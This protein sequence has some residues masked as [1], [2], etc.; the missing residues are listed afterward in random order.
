MNVTGPQDHPVSSDIWEEPEMKRALVDRDVSTVYRLLRRVGIS[1]RQIAALTGQS[2][3][4]VSE[5]LK[6]RQVMAY[7]VLARIS[8]GLGIPRGFMGLA[9]DEATATSV[10]GPPD[11]ALAEEDE[12]VKR[13]KLLSHGAAMLFGTTVLGEEVGEW[14][15]SAAQTPAPS[16][17]GMTDVKQVEAATRAMRQL[18]YQ[19]GGG[20]CRDAVV[21]QLSWAQRLL[22]AS[23]QDAVR[24]RLFRALADLQNLAGWTTF[25]VGLLDSSRNHFAKALE[26][27]RESGDYSLMSNIMYRVGR[28]YLHIQAPNDALKWFQLGQIAAQNSGSELAVAVLCGN[29]AWAYA[30]MGDDAQ[31]KKLLNRSRD[32]L[33]RA[34]L[35]DAPDWARFYNGTDLNAMTGTI[36]TELSA[37][38]IHHAALA[39]PAL[40][41]ALAGYTDSMSRSRAFMLTALATNHLRQGDVDHGVRVGREALGLAKGLKS[42][43]VADRMEPLEIAT[44]GR[45]SSADARDLNHLIRQY[46]DRARSL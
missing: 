14:L 12:S 20:A 30:M 1:Q 31:A 22:S 40:T 35:S 4:E 2:Q 3:S 28:I 43:R 13:R 9:Y 41:Q 46:R 29:E 21:A 15:T 19:F 10:V 6:G 24:Q 37:S 16:H 17:I 18:D 26:L 36:H 33:A 27:V 5:I 25:D 7:D 8:D 42:A 45:P 39:I 11:D 34:D 32:E 38:D 23:S 44:A